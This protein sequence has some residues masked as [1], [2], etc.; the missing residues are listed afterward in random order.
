MKEAANKHGS[1]NC[2]LDLHINIT[3]LQSEESHLL[4]PSQTKAQT[5]RYSKM[6]TQRRVP[7]DSLTEKERELQ[8]KDGP[9]DIKPAVPK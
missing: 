9:S 7:I 5:F 3:R 6:A 4:F 8:P 2:R 1:V